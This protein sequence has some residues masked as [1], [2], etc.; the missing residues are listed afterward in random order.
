MAIHATHELVFIVAEMV[1]FFS[2]LLLFLSD[3]G[4]Q[5]LWQQLHKNE[6]HLVFDQWGVLLKLWTTIYNPKNEKRFEHNHISFV[7]TEFSWPRCH[8]MTCSFVVL[9]KLFEFGMKMENFKKKIKKK[10]RKKP[11]L[12]QWTPIRAWRELPNVIGLN[13]LLN[14]NNLPFLTMYQSTCSRNKIH[15]GNLS[16]RPILLCHW[17][18]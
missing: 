14:W 7:N 15:I 18:P 9:I 4:L 11:F 13:K 1:F 5:I 6:F 3:V 17:Y 12:Q 8:H 16:V 2:F 10:N